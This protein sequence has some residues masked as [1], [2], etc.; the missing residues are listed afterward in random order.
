[1]SARRF[2][3]EPGALAAGPGAELELAPEEA[4]HA[5]KVLRLAPGKEVE[6]TDAR[7]A[8]AA[9][10]L[11]RAG[12][13]GAACRL[14]RVWRPAP[15]E[16]RL[17]ACPGLAK[18]PAM[19]L[20]AQ[21]LSEMGAER[22]CPVVCARSVARPKDPA[23]KAARWQRLADLA[24]KQCGAARAPE[25]LEPRPLDELLAAAPAGALRLML[26]E[27]ETGPTLAQA[28]AGRPAEVWVLTGPEGGFT[29]REAE[30]ARAAGFLTCRL[31]GAILR[32]ETAALAA[33]AVV[34]FGGPGPGPEPAGA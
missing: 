13:R 29:P 4:A 26:Y 19:E 28:L 3:V 14:L 27:E 34:R 21:K 30:A 2:L 7:G 23:A 11:V 18:G 32:A 31:P 16:P 17:V 5:V 33:A 9:A 20:L 6:L 8:M 22:L 10:E 1:M 24:L 12:R 15:P 25:V